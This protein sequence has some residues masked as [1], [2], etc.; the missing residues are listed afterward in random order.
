MRRALTILA[1][2]VGLL[3]AFTPAATA[4]DL[5]EEHARCTQ[6]W[7]TEFNQ[8]TRLC[9]RLWYKDLG[10]AV[11]LK[12]AE[13]Y[14]TNPRN[15]EPSGYKVENAYVKCGTVA[16]FSGF[17]RTATESELVIKNPENIYCPEGQ[18][19]FGGQGVLV[20]SFGFD[21]K[22]DYGNPPNGIPVD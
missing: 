12:K 14:N 22:D 9:M 4:G 20:W 18:V 2:T 21:W 1:T 11:I 17:N 5:L 13:F 8:T 19:T 15:A 3:F 16:W 7:N 10:S 6:A